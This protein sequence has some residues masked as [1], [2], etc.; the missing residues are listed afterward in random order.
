V[1]PVQPGRHYLYLGLEGVDIPVTLN[2]GGGKAHALIAHLFERRRK[3]LFR[4]RFRWETEQFA[5]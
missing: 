5:S 3:S 2:D 4:H 1:V